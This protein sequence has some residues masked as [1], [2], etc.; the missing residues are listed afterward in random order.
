M[1]EFFE[2]EIFNQFYHYTSNLNE[3]LEQDA[4]MELMTRR[5]NEIA[6]IVTT[7][8]SD[9]VYLRISDIDVVPKVEQNLKDVD[10]KTCSPVKMRIIIAYNFMKDD[11]FK[12][13]Y[14]IEKL[15]KCY[16]VD[17]E[18]YG[19][20][21]VLLEIILDDSYPNKLPTHIEI[22]KSYSLNNLKLTRLKEL[23]GCFCKSNKSCEL[24]LNLISEVRSYLRLFAEI[25]DFDKSLLSSFNLQTFKKIANVSEQVLNCVK[26]KDLLQLN[27]VKIKSKAIFSNIDNTIKKVDIELS[28]LFG[29]VLSN[30]ERVHFNYQTEFEFFHNGTNLKLKLLFPKC[31]T[32]YYTYC[33]LKFVIHRT[34]Y[35]AYTENF[36]RKF[37]L[38]IYQFNLSAIRN[39]YLHFFVSLLPFLQG[40]LKKFES[41][42]LKQFFSLNYDPVDLKETL[43]NCIYYEMK[44]PP[45]MDDVK[46]DSQHSRKPKYVNSTIEVVLVKEPYLSSDESAHYFSLLEIQ[47]AFF[48][49]KPEL[50]CDK[51]ALYTVKLLKALNFLHT[52]NFFHGEFALEKIFLSNN[53]NIKLFDS[54]LD[55]YVSMILPTIF[56]KEV[57]IKNDFSINIKSESVSIFDSSLFHRLRMNDVYNFGSFVAS[58][59]TDLNFQ[60]VLSVFNCDLTLFKVNKLLIK[61]IDDN[62]DDYRIR[63]I[64]HR[65]LEVEENKRPELYTLFDNSFFVELE[66]KPIQ[67]QNSDL[68]VMFSENKSHVSESSAVMPIDS[69]PKEPL[70]SRF[71]SDFY[72]L[73]KLGS[74]SIMVW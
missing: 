39:E 74:G 29:S 23:I 15:L 34:D 3:L 5:S 51:A 52:N 73:D 8:Y 62:I 7:F 55:T 67:P 63:D 27:Q 68:T 26:D 10:F 17:D 1:E 58:L 22:V 50:G 38:S 16:N 69:K 33:K 61:R 54:F 47:K 19:K 49:G 60:P 71:S 30:D 41:Q 65:C 13:I 64:I 66:F 36:D 20:I 42:F 28:K 37:R 45:K 25:D 32:S 72:I 21:A 12:N 57:E 48:I 35:E 11:Q 46:L 53:G 70:P 40:R 9:I 4:Q 18:F 43:S 31:K 59:Y 56:E 44:F 24:L 2:N 14:M 6:S